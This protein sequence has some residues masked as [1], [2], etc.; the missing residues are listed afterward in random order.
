MTKEEALK[1]LV[2]LERSNDTESA[3]ARADEILVDLIGDKGIAV[4]Y[5]NIG[6]WYA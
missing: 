1:E 6:K 3:H 5:G 2:E 4:A